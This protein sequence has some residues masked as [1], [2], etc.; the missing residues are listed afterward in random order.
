MRGIER[1][2]KKRLKERSSHE[3]LQD[4]LG[5][6]VSL[7]TL[8]LQFEEWEAAERS[9]EVAVSVS[10]TSADAL[11]GLG[12]SLARQKKFDLSVR[13]FA[14][15]VM[16]EPS[17]AEAY[18]E[19]GEVLRTNLQFGGAITCFKHALNKRNRLPVDLRI[20][21]LMQ[22]GELYKQTGDPSAASNCFE[23]VM[24]VRPDHLD[25]GRKV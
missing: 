16:H 9:F 18:I 6:L 19:W 1:Y 12:V 5:A 11:Y 20:S 2:K 24:R 13:A 4:H 23:E 14:S 22:L 25:A 7:G 15:C 10:K 17:H 8:Q 21:V 3:T